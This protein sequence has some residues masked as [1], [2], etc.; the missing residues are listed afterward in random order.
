MELGGAGALLFIGPATLNRWAVVLTQHELAE[1]PVDFIASYA[2]HASQHISAH[3]VFFAV[4]YL[5][6][7]GLPKVIL[8]IALLRNKL[9]AYPL[10]LLVLGVFIIY[11]IYALVYSHSVGLMLLT[12][13]DFFVVWLVWQEYRKQRIEFAR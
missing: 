2:L 4:A 13:F 9:W 7:H 8:A 6:I 11:Q 5:A 1:E 3:G 10:S 12:L